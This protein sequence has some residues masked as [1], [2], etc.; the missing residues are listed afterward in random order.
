M[1][2]FHKWCS[3]LLVG[4]D[5]KYGGERAQRSELK[6]LNFGKRAVFLGA[7]KSVNCVNRSP[8]RLRTP[9][10]ES[11]SQAWEACMIP[12]HYV[13]ADS[14]S[15]AIACFSDHPENWTVGGVHAI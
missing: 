1:R 4:M 10:I 8:K 7:M 6:L 13:R 15:D 12:L 2:Q 14:G 5:D 11:G 3:D 9:G